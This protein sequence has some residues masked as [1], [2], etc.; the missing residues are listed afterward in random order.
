MLSMRGLRA[1]ARLGR[2]RVLIVDR[3]IPTPD[4]DAGSRSVFQ[5]LCLFAAK[6]FDVD[7]WAPAKRV[8][9]RYRDQLVACGARVH[10]LDPVPSPDFAQWLKHHGPDID[11]VFLSRPQI[12]MRVID[13]V[14]EFC[15]GRIL[16]YGHDLHHLR[17]RMELAH[18][19][20]EHHAARADALEAIESD[21]WR[22]V[23]TVYY[24]S[25]D[26]CRYVRSRLDAG[27]EVDVR[28]LPVFGFASFDEPSTLSPQGR[29]GVLFVG[30]FRH[31]PNV[32]GILWFAHDIWP[33]IASAS[34]GS[35]LTVVGSRPPPEILALASE[36][37]KVRGFIPDD[38]L[39]R[40]YRSARVAIA[41]LRF[42]AGMKGKVAE[43]MRFGVPMV[44]TGVGAQGLADAGD[45]LLISDDAGGQGELVLRLLR[46]DRLWGSTAAAAATFARHH[47]SRE[48]QWAALAAAI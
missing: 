39:E 43:A 8:E 16:F 15:P 34:P 31:S 25:P 24:P 19:G 42:G 7:F 9:D 18:A 27:H 23:D 2:R 13:L 1:V 36:T 11:V 10:I 5:V 41:P 26:E 48:R 29:S 38:A 40:A 14:R 17:L 22:R 28:V 32:D 46:D 21:I 4:Q 35:R 44:T 12:A 33:A 37:I 20:A 30:G 47:F 6:R 45:A 3:R